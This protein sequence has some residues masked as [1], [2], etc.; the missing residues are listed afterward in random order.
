MDTTSPD[1]RRTTPPP[2]ALCGFAFDDIAS[3][4]A[5]ESAVDTANLDIFSPFS[6]SSLNATP[7]TGEFGESSTDAPTSP[8][9]VRLDVRPTVPAHTINT[10]FH[11]QMQSSKIKLGLCCMDV[12]AHSSAMRVLVSRIT[13]YGDFEVVEFPDDL[14]LNKPVSDWPI[15]DC[16]IAFFS[17]G[18]PLDKAIKYAE[19]YPDM[20]VLNDLPKQNLFFSRVKVFDLLKELDIPHPPHIKMLRGDDVRENEKFEMEE[21]LDAITVNGVR[22]EKPFVEKPISGEDHNIC[23]YYHSSQ[24]GG[25]RRLFRKIGDKSSSFSPNVSSVRRDQSYIYEKFIKCKNAQRDIKVYT[26]GMDY[27]H[28]ESREAPT[29]GEKVKR[30]MQGRERRFI[31][32]LTRDELTYASRIVRAT[33]QMICGIDMLRAEGGETYV[34]DVNGWSSVKSKSDYSQRCGR[35]L[36]YRFLNSMLQR[37][38]SAQREER[39]NHPEPDV[40]ENSESLVVMAQTKEAHGGGDIPMVNSFSSIPATG[41]VL[42]GQIAVFRHAD[43]T[44]KQKIKIKMKIPQM[45]ELFGVSSTTSSFKQL[46]YKNDKDSKDLEKLVQVVNNILHGG[47]QPTT[48]ANRMSGNS[49]WF[50]SSPVQ[51]GVDPP[52]HIIEG[53]KEEDVSRLEV[54]YMVLR[55]G[56]AGLKVQIKPL[57][58][59]LVTIEDKRCYKVSRVLFVCKWGGMLTHTGECQSRIMGNWFRANMLPTSSDA[60]L[61]IFLK[62][63]RVF[64]NNERRVRATADIFTAAFAHS[65]NESVEFSDDDEY[66]QPE[67][68]E[69][70]ERGEMVDG[71]NGKKYLVNNTHN[72]KIERLKREANVDNYVTENPMTCSLL[73]DSSEAKYLMEDMKS[74]ILQR[75]NSKANDVEFNGKRMEKMMRELLPPGKYNLN[76][77]IFREALLYE[78]DLVCEVCNEITQLYKK[79]VHH[80]FYAGETLK[81]VRRRWFFLKK[82]LYNPKTQGN[83]PR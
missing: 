42:H 62:A 75:A 4:S 41:K 64:S 54:I 19:M 55:Q 3:D 66:I 56:H 35:F 27:A 39:R 60:E 6:N 78:Y 44:P 34:C 1:D 63:L 47:A 46:K 76:G 40:M 32:K 48:I 36:R 69:G 25:C 52:P 17:T 8:Q 16:L 43:R 9:S 71:G 28:A 5:N 30:T 81:S 20:I 72:E 38:L 37:Q 29:T 13:A 12:K 80:V 2:D 51:H 11:L 83:I 23:V 26:I 67:E 59:E 15:C 49:D 74:T 82:C 68:Y 70:G 61:D 53:M 10:R 79:P 7:I 18:F 22:F 50:S 58:A 57:A 33:G 45:C 31:V 21:E 65:G 24:G 77:N 14:K 73:G